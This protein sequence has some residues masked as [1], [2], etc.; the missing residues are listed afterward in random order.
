MYEVKCLALQFGGHVNMFE[1][2]HSSH[3]SQAQL[4]AVFCTNTPESDLWIVVLR[5]NQ[6]F[7]TIFMSSHVS[8]KYVADMIE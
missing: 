4:R 1:E 3:V 7:A 5:S 2:T 6:H 8:V